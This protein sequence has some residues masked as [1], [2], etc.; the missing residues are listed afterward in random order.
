MPK[1]TILYLFFSNNFPTSK[2]NGNFLGLMF[3]EWEELFF[4]LFHDNFYLLPCQLHFC[5][6]LPFFFILGKNEGA[7]A[8]IMSDRIPKSWTNQN[9]DK[10]L[11]VRNVTWIWPI[12]VVRFWHE[13]KNPVGLEDSV[14]KVADKEILSSVSFHL[15][16]QWEI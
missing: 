8:S 9:E 10:L 16:A 12:T 11:E 6:F 2:I 15:F 14:G 3:C 7:P 5:W 4:A 13:G 1:Y